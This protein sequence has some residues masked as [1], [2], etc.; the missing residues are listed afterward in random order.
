M[1][2]L[3]VG[4][5][6][7]EW[8]ATQNRQCLGLIVLN[9]R[10]R[11]ALDV[12]CADR[13]GNGDALALE[14][15][16][17]IRANGV[18]GLIDPGVVPHV[19]LDL[20]DH[21]VIGKIDQKNFYFRLCQNVFSRKGCPEQCILYHIGWVFIFNSNA[22]PHGVNFGRIVEIHDLVAHHLVVRDIEINV[23]VGA[24]SRGAPVNLHDLG[25]PFAYL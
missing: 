24:E 19:V 2:E 20:V 5:T 12:Q 6:L 14:F 18:V 7:E 25:E 13:E 10:R 8:F 4:K 3:F 15:V 23:V 1:V 16:P 21:G 17:N 11:F 22:N 9:G